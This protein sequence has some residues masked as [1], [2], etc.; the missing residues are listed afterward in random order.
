MKA[1][2]ITVNIHEAKTQ[3]SKY[4]KKAEKGQI[5]IVC[6][7]NVPI[8]EIRAM[9]SSPVVDRKKWFGMDKGKVMI[10]PEFFD[11]IPD[12]FLAYFDGRK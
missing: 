4:L 2:T 9:S 3:F 11:P 12:D 7:R 8:A 5:I 10:E 1:K 6:R